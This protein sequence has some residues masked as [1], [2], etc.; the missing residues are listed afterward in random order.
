MAAPDHPERRE[1]LWL[2]TVS[3]LIWSAHFVLS[4]A[5]V[6]VWCAKSGGSLWNARVA[7]IVYTV[8]ALAGIAVTCWFGFRRHSFGTVTSTHDFDSPAGRHGFLGF[9]VVLLSGLSAIATLYVALPILFIGTC[10]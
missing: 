10:R 8:V 1:S 3:P 5:T 9:S 4:Y 2:L 6:A 7:I